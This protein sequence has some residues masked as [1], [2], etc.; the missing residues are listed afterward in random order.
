MGGDF[1]VGQSFLGTRERVEHGAAE[2]VPAMRR[3]VGV[4]FSS[5][6]NL[7]AWSTVKDSQPVPTIGVEHEVSLEPLRVNRK[8]LH[9]MFASGVAELDP[10]LRTIVSATTLAELQASAQ[11]PEEGFL[12]PDELWVRTVY[13]FAASHHKAVIS[14]D[15]VIQALAPLYRGKAL[16]FVLENREASAEEVEKNVEA[17]CLSFESLKPYLLQL[18][19]GGK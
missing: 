10:V 3:T 13:E 5:L 12:F 11:Q 19:D 1:R 9:Q 14:R 16:A 17:L 4:L 7:S 2:L 8:R 15:H 6:E 18:W